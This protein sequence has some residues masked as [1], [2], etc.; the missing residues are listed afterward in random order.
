MGPVYES[1][2]LEIQKNQRKH[3]AQNVRNDKTFLLGL[4]ILMAVTAVR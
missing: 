1:I 2:P 4:E 3:G